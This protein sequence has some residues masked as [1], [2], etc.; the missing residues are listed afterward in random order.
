MPKILKITAEE[1][2]SIRH[3]VMWPDEPLDFV[4]L[5][6]DEEGRHF[7]LFLNGNLISV[8]SLFITDK[9][10]QFR[11]FA[12]LTQY[13]GKGYGTL[14]LKE[15]MAIA[16]QKQVSKIWCNARQGK[17]GFYSRFGMKLTAETFTKAGIDYVIME[18]KF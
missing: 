4:R 5:P 14:L 15:I 3:Q 7:G 10:A 1:T 8:V 2:L 17:T 16:E 13:Q 6:N 9:K 18:R 12:T 11:K